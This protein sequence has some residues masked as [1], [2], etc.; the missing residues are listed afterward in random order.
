MAELNV[1]DGRDRS[2]GIPDDNSFLGLATRLV[3]LSLAAARLQDRV[4][5]VRRRALRNAAAARR[6]A[7]L[8]ADSEVDPRHVA[9]MLEVARSM[10]AAAEAT[11]DMSRAS[12][13]VTRAAE[14]AAGA[15][16]AEYEGVYEA[17]QDLQR[18]GIR[19]PKPG[20]LRAN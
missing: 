17:A 9:A 20:F 18:Q 4:T 12:E 8:M 16:R 2:P 14:D 11:T 5:G 19:Q 3:R 1:P 7:E 10:E 6:M 13:V 15:H